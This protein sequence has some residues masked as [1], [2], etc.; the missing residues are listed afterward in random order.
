VSKKLKSVGVPA[1]IGIP[2]YS[3]WSRHFLS[4]FYAKDYDRIAG[5]DKLPGIS[6]LDEAVAIR[7][8]L[9]S[10]NDPRFLAW[11]PIFKEFTATWAPEYLTQPP[12]NADAA[13]QDFVAG[14]AAMY[15]SGSWLPY[16]L[17]AAKANFVYS[18]F[19]FPVLGTEVAP[20]STGVDVSNAV[21]G[22]NAAYQYAI[23]TPAANASMKEAG[24]VDAVLDWLRY[25]GTPRVIQEVVDEKDS[26][27]PTWPNT[28]ARPG[29][30]LLV[31]QANQPLRSVTSTNTSPQ[32]DADLQRVFAQYLAGLMSLEQAGPQVQLALDRAVQDYAARNNVNLDDY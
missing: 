29:S 26:Y 28:R 14:K 5:F 25:I 18:A 8:G 22:P 27:I 6:A 10:T 13:F 4:D 3:W 16:D 7:K 9:F 19:N 23:S 30:E 31:S 20:F 21:G 17:R 32:L 12:E 2:L 1:S 11:W 24:K 15:Y